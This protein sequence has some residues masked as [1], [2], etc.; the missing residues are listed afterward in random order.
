MAAVPS[1][2]FPF[3]GSDT[4]SYTG[5][6]IPLDTDGFVPQS[7]AD[8]KIV[9]LGARAD[10]AYGDKTLTAPASA[11]ALLKAIFGALA[12]LLAVDTVVRFTP[13]SRSGTIGAGGVSQA[14]MA[15]NTQRRGFIIQ[16]Q[17]T[18]PLWYNGLTAAAMD[19]TSY[20]VD[21]GETYE[22]P[23]HHSGTGAISIIGATTGQAFYAREF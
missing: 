9:G 15:A 22:T 11:I 8:G 21:A 20:R 3:K 6:T 13:A 7:A 2:A 5:Q 16:N 14:W 4:N 1:V 19:S 18:G 12:N 10:A 17:S 23:V